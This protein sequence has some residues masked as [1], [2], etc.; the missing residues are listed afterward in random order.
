[1]AGYHSSEIMLLARCTTHHSSC[2]WSECFFQACL[3]IITRVNSC[4]E[5]GWTDGGGGG[6][7]S[8]GSIKGSEVR[9]AMW[10]GWPVQFLKKQA[11][12]LAN[13]TLCEQKA[14][15]VGS[16]R[17]LILRQLVAGTEALGSICHRSYILLTLTPKYLKRETANATCS[18]TGIFLVSFCTS[19]FPDI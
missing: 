2:E 16:G 10:P 5:C 14:W 9:R 12:M 8:N 11:R 19:A 15:I 1:M 13:Y 18:H 4:A 3:Y 7:G 17:E 6:V